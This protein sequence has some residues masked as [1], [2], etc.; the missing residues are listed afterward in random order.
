MTSCVDCKSPLANAVS[1]G[2]LVPVGD[3]K[4]GL[5]SEGG[6]FMS[7]VISWLILSF[8]VWLT[9]MMLP[10]FQV[11]GFTGALVVSAIFGAINWLLGWFFYVVIGIAT[12]G[13]GFL[14]S[15]VT[16]WFV[17]A[18]LLSMTGALT[19]KLKIKNFKWALLG[20]LVI[21]VLSAVVHHVIRYT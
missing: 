17:D 13:I 3:K 14:L 1:L 4:L 5:L 20:A 11:R 2:A 16:H 6:K 21:S 8:I 12:L 9:A 10:G 19:D 7:I 18:I 15:V